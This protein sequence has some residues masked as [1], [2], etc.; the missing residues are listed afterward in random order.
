MT[1]FSQIKSA[2][3]AWEDKELAAAVTAL[4]E[5]FKSQDL[6]PDD[7]VPVMVMGIAVAL[8]SVATDDEGVVK[9]ANV[10]CDMLIDAVK[11]DAQ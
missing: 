7:A 9:G 11:A 8:A 2:R 3:E 5:W 6:G 10:V 1:K 4:A